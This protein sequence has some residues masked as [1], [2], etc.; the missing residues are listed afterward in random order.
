MKAS[1]GRANP[2]SEAVV[3]AGA[4]EPWQ[5]TL[6]AIARQHLRLGTLEPRDADSLD[7]HEVG[8]AA[9][10]SALQAAYRAGLAAGLRH[11]RTNDG[12]ADPR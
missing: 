12:S 6:A 3:S 4:G 11:P 8:V 9:L 7:V 5:T 1:S 10:R 2:P